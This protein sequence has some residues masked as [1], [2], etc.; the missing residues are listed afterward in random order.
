MSIYFP[1]A[2]VN[3]TQPESSRQPGYTCP[4]E[5]PKLFAIFHNRKVQPTDESPEG[6]TVETPEREPCR[7]PGDTRPGTWVKILNLTSPVAH[8]EVGT[9]HGI[10]RRSCQGCG[11]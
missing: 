5:R 11:V 7:Q 1:G 10:I 8:T 4:G 3:T 9:V 6:S 2:A